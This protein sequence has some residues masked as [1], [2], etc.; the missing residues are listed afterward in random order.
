MHTLEVHNFDP[1]KSVNMIN[2]ILWLIGNFRVIAH[3]RVLRWLRYLD[4]PQD[5][6]DRLLDFWHDIV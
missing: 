6:L 5:D 1:R 3:P 2:S 4:Y